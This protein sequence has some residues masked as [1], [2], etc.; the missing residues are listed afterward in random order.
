MASASFLATNNLSLY[1]YTPRKMRIGE[2]LPKELEQYSTELAGLD[3][4]II[5]IPRARDENGKCHRLLPTFLLPYKHYSAMEV[6]SAFCNEF[7]QC[8][9]A[10]E[11]TI[12]RWRKWWYSICMEFRTKALEEKKTTK[13][14]AIIAATN[15]T[16]LAYT[17]KR[18]FPPFWMSAILPLF[19]SETLRTFSHRL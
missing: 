9:T 16:T 10:S 1:D 15:E 6:A 5:Y 13:F 2:S 8:S 17:L 4:V 12:K 18:I 7:G 19:S 11:S 14:Y 3:Y